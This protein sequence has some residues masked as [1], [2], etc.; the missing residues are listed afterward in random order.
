MAAFYFLKALCQPVVLIRDLE[1][2][3]F[4][5]G[6]LSLLGDA[7]QLRCIVAVFLRIGHV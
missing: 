2:L 6:T 7:S 5:D 4:D 3:A 1:H